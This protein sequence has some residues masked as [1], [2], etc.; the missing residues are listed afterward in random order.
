VTWHPAEAARCENV[1]RSKTSVVQ[2]RR[3]KR[4]LA[5]GVSE[6]RK[7]LH[8]AHAATRQQR[9]RRDR[10]TYAGDQF[11][12][13]AG[14]GADAREVDDDDG[15]GAGV[16]GPRRDQL[17]RVTAGQNSAQAGECVSEQRLAVAQVEAERHA[18]APD[19]G[20]YFSQRFVR[21]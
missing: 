16:N 21:G 8:A 7:I 6:P 11:D 17:G 12:I 1:S 19:C 18:V 20:T 15:A 13:R 14:V 9:H 5:P 2:R 3:Y 10:I 4:A